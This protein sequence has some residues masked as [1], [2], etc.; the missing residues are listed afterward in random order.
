MAACLKPRCTPTHL[1]DLQ[2]HF[3]GLPIRLFDFPR[4]V[5]FI[6]LRTGT[7]SK[8]DF[9]EPVGSPP[10]TQSAESST[11]S[12]GS[13]ASMSMGAMAVAEGGAPPAIFRRR[14]CLCS[15][16]RLLAAA[17]SA[18]ASASPCGG[19]ASGP[20]ALARL[21]VKTQ[22]GHSVNLLEA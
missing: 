14:G 6:E 21:A 12:H 22:A 15:L 19:G 17:G 9:S 4:P 13:S 8:S 18:A 1:E 10:G 20:I 11:L 5:V 7:S 16:L 2:L 3:L